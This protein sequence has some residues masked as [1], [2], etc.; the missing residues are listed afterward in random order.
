MS[1]SALVGGLA[2]S[3]RA[4]P[5]L[6]RDADVAVSVADDKEAEAVVHEMVTVGY[7]P[8]AVLEQ[9]VAGRL[10]TV[11]LIH[12]DRPDVVVDLLF[13]STGIEPEIVGQAEAVEVLPDLVVPVA[14]AGHLIA[15]KLLARDDRH[16]P[17][18]ADDLRAL[19]AVAGFEDWAAARHAVQ[20]ITERGFDR[21]RDLLTAWDA[22]RAAREHTS[23]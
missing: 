19:G 2:V 17:A 18:D 10:A 9:Y 12:R 15:M 14:T 16:R 8:A 4:E 13:A 6:T 11:R 5:R 20:L 7:H 21:G 1:R 23:S 3:A 22:L